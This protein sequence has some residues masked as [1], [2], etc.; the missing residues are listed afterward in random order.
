MPGGEI[1]AKVDLD[2]G[3]PNNRGT[4]QFFFRMKK[5]VDVD[6]A[7]LMAYLQGKIGW[8][9]SILECMSTSFIISHFAFPQLTTVVHRLVRPSHSTETFRTARPYPPQLLPTHRTF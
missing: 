2:E 1:R 3:R 4:N 8:D 9:N 5:T 7:P 6:F